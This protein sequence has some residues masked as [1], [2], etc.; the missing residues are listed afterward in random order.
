MI[1]LMNAKKKKAELRLYV[2]P[3]TD[4]LV[5][6]LAGLTDQTVSELVENALKEYL[7]QKY[8]NLVEKHRLDQ[9]DE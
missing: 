3:T 9:L 7:P 2:E 5:K 1:A 6:T 8:Q 4:R